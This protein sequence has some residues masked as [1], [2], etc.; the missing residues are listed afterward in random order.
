[1]MQYNNHTLKPNYVYGIFKNAKMQFVTNLVKYKCIYSYYKIML[2]KYGFFTFICTSRLRYSA[3]YIFYSPKE[4]QTHCF[5]EP[6]K[7][8]S[9]SAKKIVGEKGESVMKL[10]D[11]V[12]ILLNMLKWHGIKYISTVKCLDCI[13]S[14]ELMAWMMMVS[15]AW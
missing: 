3:Y 11:N 14:Y 13:S 2:E 8:Q 12:D 6:E 4:L 15:S 9:Q 5:N 10:E 7:P 1:M